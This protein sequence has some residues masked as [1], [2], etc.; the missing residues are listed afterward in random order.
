MT[1]E[2]QVDRAFSQF[3]AMANNALKAVSDSLRDA[4]I[5]EPPQPKQK[6]QTALPPLLRTPFDG[7]VSR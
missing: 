1:K 2:T 7:T 5:P 4:E 3:F 6:K